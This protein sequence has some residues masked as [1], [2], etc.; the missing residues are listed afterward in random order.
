MMKNLRFISAFVISSAVLAGCSASGYQVFLKPGAGVDRVNRDRAECEVEA[1]RLFP[2]ANFPNTI[3]Y[4]TLG[5]YG[6]GWGYGV[7][8]IHTTDVNAGMRNDHRNQCMRVKGY[9]PYVFPVC[10][11]EQLAGGSFAP[12]IRSPKPSP[13]ICAVT[14]EGGG[15]ALIDLSKPL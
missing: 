11:S 15:R 1:N 4:G 5:Y 12:L 7:G 2:S 8:I 3:P 10:T 13:T 9:E 6:G 14:V